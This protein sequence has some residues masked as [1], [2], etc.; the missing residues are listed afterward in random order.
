MR[1]LVDAAKNW[2]T[3]DGLWFRAVETRYGLD[4]AIECDKAV[5][6]QFSAV[7]AG[8]IMDRCGLPG[9]GGLDALEIALKH[10][11]FALVNVQEIVRPDKDTVLYYM[12]TCRTQAARERKGLPLFPC[13]P[14]GIVDHETFARTI[15]PRIS[16]ECISCPPDAPAPD[17]C[18]GWRFTLRNG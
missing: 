8:R 3:M 2:L 10:R 5:W 9:N 13:K 16:V 18:C 15:D 12:R 14:I 17:F 1:E 4:A 7:E 6:K 11:L